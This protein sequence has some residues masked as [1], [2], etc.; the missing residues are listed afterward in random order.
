MCKID[1]IVDVRFCQTFFIAKFIDSSGQRH[2]SRE[3]FDEISL[4]N[5]AN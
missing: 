5:G 1:T 3:I 4:T 2:A